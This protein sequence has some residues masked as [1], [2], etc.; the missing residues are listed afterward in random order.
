LSLAAG[1]PSA[2]RLS[3]GEV[4]LILLNEWSGV[5]LVSPLKSVVVDPV[6]VD[7]LSLRRVDLILVTHEHPH[8]L[9]EELVADIQRETRCRVLANTASAEGLRDYLPKG[10]LGVVKPDAELNLDDVSVRVYPSNHPMA[11]APVTY[12]VTMENGVKVFHTSDSL[13]Y[14]GME[15]IGRDEKPDI[16]LC[17]TGLDPALSPATGAQVARQVRARL[18]IPYHGAGQEEFAEML[19]K[20]GLKAVVLKQG[21]VFVYSGS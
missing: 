11:S 3:K 2:F 12:M 13:P 17:A 18:A 6:Q 4:A 14:P 5:E 10:F 20:E 19:G 1:V 9:D 7:P 15:R 21:D 16:V 8:H